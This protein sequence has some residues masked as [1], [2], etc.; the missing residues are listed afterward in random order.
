VGE[1]V[2]DPLLAATLGLAVPLRLVELREW[3]QHFDDK[4]WA[5]AQADATAAAQ[6]VIQEVSDGL[7]FRTR[8]GVAQRGFVALV[9]AIAWLAWCPGGI[10]IFGQHWEERPA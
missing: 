8:P 4:G 10:T 5:R 6:A 3:R 1:G 9:D 7:L 2:N